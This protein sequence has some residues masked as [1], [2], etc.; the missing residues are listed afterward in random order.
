MLRKHLKLLTLIIFLAFDT[1]SQAQESGFGIKG[2]A[3][4][5]V[6]NTDDVERN[7]WI[8][9]FNGGFTGEF[10]VNE[11]LGIQSEIIYTVKGGKTTYNES[12]LG[13]NIVD[14]VTN[15]RLSY[16]EVPMHLSFYLS[17]AFRTYAG[18]YIGF[19][20]KSKV[21]TDAEILQF[22]NVDDEEQI[23]NE[24]FNNVDYGVSGGVEFILDPVFLG[25]KYSVGLQQVANPDEPTNEILGNAKNNTFQV[26]LGIYLK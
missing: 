26:Y 24:Y 12:F 1:I 20:M 3:S 9:G 19:L 6:L 25:A 13:L 5:S 22:V 4:F 10:M 17:D 23:D 11:H 21:E 18:P 8:L 2:G 15:M 14:G 7:L 16:I